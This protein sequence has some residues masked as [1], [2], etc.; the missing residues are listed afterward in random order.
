MT[1]AEYKSLRQQRG[2]L[3]EVAALLGVHWVTLQKRESGASGWPISTEAAL[4]MQ[5][6]KPKK[7]RSPT[8]KPRQAKG[9]NAE[10][11]DGGREA[12]RPE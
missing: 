7:K 1:P 4:A 8:K 3:K 9:H 10:V 5:S 12:S 11:T 6:L 2:T